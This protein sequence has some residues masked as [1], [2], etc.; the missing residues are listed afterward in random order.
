M[1][2]RLTDSGFRIF[3]LGHSV[4]PSCDKEETEEDVGIGL[5]RFRG[6]NFSDGRL[7]LKITGGLHPA[8]GPHTTDQLDQKRLPAKVFDFAQVWVHFDVRLFHK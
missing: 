1:Q 8:E 3:A 6:T 4:I 5:V 7:P 2:N